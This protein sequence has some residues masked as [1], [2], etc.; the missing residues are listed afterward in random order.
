MKRGL[1]GLS[2]SLAVSTTSYFVSMKRGLK[3]QTSPHCHLVL[4]SQ[5]DE[6][7]IESFNIILWITL[8]VVNGYSMKRGL[9]EDRSRREG[10]TGDKACSKVFTLKTTFTSS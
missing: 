8:I 1:K 3:V 5:L 9:K 2:N 7:R 6:K 4:T 10:F